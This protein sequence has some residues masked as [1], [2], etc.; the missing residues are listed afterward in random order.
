MQAHAA[1]IVA[2]TLAST[3]VK[4][5]GFVNASITV[6]NAGKPVVRQLVSLFNLLT[7]AVKFTPSGG[8]VDVA[9]ARVD[10]QIQ[11]SV[12]DSGIGIAPEDQERIFEEFQQVSAAKRVST[13]GT[14][15]GLPLARRFVELHGGRLWVLS[16][17]GAGS[18]FTFSLPVRSADAVPAGSAAR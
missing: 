3:T 18:T 13:E 1:A 8:H 17:P 2:V 14:G 4:P 12:R 9:A 11:V 15:L 10:S 7:N 16:A 5:G 6:T